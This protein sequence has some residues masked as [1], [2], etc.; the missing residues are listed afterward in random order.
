MIRVAKSVDGGWFVLWPWELRGTASWLIVSMG[1]HELVVR[2][3]R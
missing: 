3:G 1:Q 2:R